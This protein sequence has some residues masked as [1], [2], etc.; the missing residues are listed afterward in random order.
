MKI[1]EIREQD[2]ADLLKRIKEAEKE[3]LSIRVRKTASDG[4]SASGIKV[5][6]LRKTIARAKTV[7]TEREMAEKK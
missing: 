1:K 7:M 3:I 4:T 6:G 2:N 5:R